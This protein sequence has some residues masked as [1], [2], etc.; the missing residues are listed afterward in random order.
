M[1]RQHRTPEIRSNPKLHAFH[2]AHDAMLLAAFRGD[3]PEM[4][5][6][7]ERVDRL[8]P[9]LKDDAYV[10]VLYQNAVDVV[11]APDP[12]ERARQIIEFK[13]PGNAES[14]AGG[15]GA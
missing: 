11:E 12:R 14:K 5:R 6:H 10:Q 3:E 7:R 2:Q 8:A 9:A 15:S 13:C 4:T 1:T